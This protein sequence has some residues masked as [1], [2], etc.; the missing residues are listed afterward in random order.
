MKQ[1]FKELERK[2]CSGNNVFG[3]GTLVVYCNF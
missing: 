2:E 1:T 3:I